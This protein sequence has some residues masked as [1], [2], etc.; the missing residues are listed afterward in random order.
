M[1]RKR[2]VSEPHQNR[3]LG[4]RKGLGTAGW[5]QVLVAGLPLLRRQRRWSQQD[6]ADASGLHRETIG[7]LERSTIEQ[8]APM[9][10][11]LRALALAFNHDDLGA[12]WTA[13]CAA[14]AEASQG[15]WVRLTS[16]QHELVMKFAQCSPEQQ[17]LI[18]VLIAFFRAQVHPR[19]PGAEP[20]QEAEALLGL[21]KHRPSRS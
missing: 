12:F 15:V 3:P 19:V 11:T 5:K 10:H 4:D 8:A 7:R 17:E 14:A 2:Q 6:L 18:C 20:V 9:E 13:L 16:Q 1:A 21:L